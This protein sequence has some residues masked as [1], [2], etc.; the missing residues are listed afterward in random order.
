[1]TNENEAAINTLRAV[2]QNPDTFIQEPARF[3]LALAL[4]KVGK[5]QE[6]TEIL[7]GFL[8][9]PTYGKKAENVVNELNKN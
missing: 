5:R 2:V 4:V 6:A 3:N 1:M 7:R 9:H 8:T